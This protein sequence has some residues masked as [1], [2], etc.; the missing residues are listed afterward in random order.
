MT[1]VG[2]FIDVALSI[3]EEGASRCS[4]IHLV[5]SGIRPTPAA[6]HGTWCVC[7]AL[8]YVRLMQA[9]SQFLHSSML[10]TFSD[11]EAPTMFDYLLS[12]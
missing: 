7:A 3:F 4:V 1:A 11:E 6:L 2:D 8:K 12:C 10:P 5:L 9:S